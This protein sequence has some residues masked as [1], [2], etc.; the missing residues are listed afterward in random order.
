[1]ADAPAADTPATGADVPDAPTTEATALGSR[2]SQSV[3]RQVP[4]GRPTAAGAP[5]QHYQ[6]LRD[7]GLTRLSVRIDNQAAWATVRFT[8]AKILMSRITSA[9][10]GTR[11]TT[12]SSDI[13]IAKA[14]SAT[15]EVALQIPSGAVPSMTTCKSWDGATTVSVRRM[16][17]APAALATVTDSGTSNTITGDGCS[18]PVRQELARADLIGPVRWPAR[19][20]ARPLVLGEYFPWWDSSN[21]N[22]FQ[23]QPTGPA[24]TSN[25]SSVASS[26]DLAMKHGVD[27]FVVEYEGSPA[28][29]P[30]I[31]SV[32]NAADARPDFKIAMQLDLDILSYRYKGI[33]N[34]LL[35][36]V[37]RGVADRASHKSQLEVNGQPVLFLYYGSRVTPSAWQAALDRLANSS[38][39]HPFVVADVTGGGLG[40]P[41]RFAFGNNGAPDAASLNSAAADDLYHLRLEPAMGDVTPPLWVASVQP[42]FD[43]TRTGRKPVIVEPR[44]GGQ[45]YADTWAATLSS[46]PDWVVITTWN[47]YDEQTQVMPG[48]TTGDLAQSQTADWAARFH[49]G[50]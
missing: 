29:D 1:V 49:A 2:H 14:G 19:F 22:S 15:V 45:R 27:G 8:G 18:N 46:L 12:S 30:R 40:A 25:P 43:N 3:V 16:T 10:D 38:G 11:V 42:G 33:S 47:G 37:L 13:G 41:G 6:L 20:D 39:L 36:T 34:E 24:D 23:D 50:G 21:L 32:Y 5:R 48:V 9:S 35:D 28:F 44:L 4:A 26:V 7:T 17:D 31:D